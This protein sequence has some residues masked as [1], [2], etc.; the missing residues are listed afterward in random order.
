MLGGESCNHTQSPIV[1]FQKVSGGAPKPLHVGAKAAAELLVAIEQLQPFQEGAKA[2]T[3]SLAI[4]RDLSNAD[5][6]RTLHRRGVVPDADTSISAVPAGA[7]SAASSRGAPSETERR[8][9]RS[10]SRSP[11]CPRTILTCSSVVAVNLALA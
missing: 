7:V 1:D 4:V 5:K 8:S 10:S 6:H 2:E 3:H 9:L 11:S